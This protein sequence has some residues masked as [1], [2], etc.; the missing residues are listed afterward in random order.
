MFPEGFQGR[1]RII[2]TPGPVF[3][4]QICSEPNPRYPRMI[5]EQPPVFPHHHQH[6]QY[7]NGQPSF[8]TPMNHGLPPPQF[9]SQ[10]FINHIN[11]PAQFA[12][13]NQWSFPTNYSHNSGP[14]ASGQQLAPR[15]TTSNHS[16]DRQIND[17]STAVKQEAIAETK[18]TNPVKNISKPTT[19]NYPKNHLSLYLFCFRIKTQMQ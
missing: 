19:V 1:P 12:F 18:N 14:F 5:T 16:F 8:F 2:G 7:T 15:F 10:G 11:H 3:P 4:G 9:H 6:L 17:Y 13:P